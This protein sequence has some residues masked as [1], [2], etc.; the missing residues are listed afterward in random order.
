MKELFGDKRFIVIT[1]NYGSGKTELS[2]NLA[3]HYAETEKT[4]LVDLDIVNPYFR[5]GEKADMLRDAGVRV[6]MPT[7]AMTTVD[8]PAL[9]A[10]IQSVFEVPSD[11]VLFDVGGDDTGAAALGR[12]YP[13]FMKER[14]NTIVALVINCMRPLTME[15][16]DIT[17]MA[18]RIENRGRLR[19]DLL[20]NNTNLADETTP[21]MIEKGEKTVLRCAEILGVPTV[22]TAGKT[23]ILRHCRLQTPIMEMQRYMKPDWMED[24]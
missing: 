24:P 3:L 8:I 20:I 12:Y 21:E 5:T 18:R 23:E 4:T 17:D 7:F 6:L 11:R 2:L 15:E 13:S 16:E 19:I 14:E 10:E 22:V 1:G 9:P